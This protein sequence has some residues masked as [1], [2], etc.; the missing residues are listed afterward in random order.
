MGV[1]E[2]QS[3]RSN[4][5]HQRTWSIASEGGDTHR[6]ALSVSASVL[7]TLLLKFPS[8]DPPPS[9]PLSKTSSLATNPSAQLLPPSGL[10]KGSSGGRN[11]SLGRPSPAPAPHTRFSHY[12][13]LSGP[14][15]E[16]DL[17]A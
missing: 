16:V 17:G 14:W 9:C 12:H 5:R 2:P 15:Y 6:R 11:P 1:Q 7:E 8:V 4:V 3:N 10:S 13:A